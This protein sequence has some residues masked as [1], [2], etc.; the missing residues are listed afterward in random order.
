MSEELALAIKR[1]NETDWSLDA[2]QSLSDGV[3][4]TARL[5]NAFE[6]GQAKQLLAWDIRQIWANDLAKSGKAWLVRRIRMPEA[7]C[8]SVLK[9][10]RLAK[11]IPGAMDA[12]S[13]GAISADHIRKIASV[14]NKR[15]QAAFDRDVD[16]FVT[17]AQNIR[18]KDFAQK[19]DEWKL[20]EDPDGSDEDEWERHARRSVSFNETLDGEGYGTIHLDKIGTAIFGGELARLYDQ[21]WR[22]DWDAAKE[23]LGRDP[24]P[25]DLERTPL[26]RRADALVQMATRSKTMPADGRKPRPLFTVVLGR[27]A[28]ERMCRIEGGA[29]IA[30]GVLSPFLSDAEVERLLFDD[31]SD[32]A[33]RVSRR[34]SFDF[35]LR[36]IADIRDQECFHEY[37]DIP[38]IQCEGDHV[39]PYSQGGLT[40]Q[41]NCRPGCRFH[42]NGRNRRGPP[43]AGEDDDDDDDD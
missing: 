37:C 23:K 12:W 17:W 1:F 30:P 20:E 13:A 42:N 9:T 21:L 16:R 33:I 7:F 15:T 25:D 22:A 24:G 5:R 35:V 38:A 2:D 36:R 39:V 8:A 29:T 31:T 10:G 11:S 18:F 4:V 19:L 34:R 43:P 6:A 32:R 41:E 26:Q 14:R 27:P 40:S 28:L 3:V